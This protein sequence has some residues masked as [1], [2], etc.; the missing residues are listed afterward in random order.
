M[1]KEIRLYGSLGKKFGRVH[2]YAVKSVHE[3]I[4]AL[5]ANFPN[6]EQEFVK[7]N[8]KYR[9]WTGTTR[10]QSAE[11][12]ILPVGYTEVIRISPVV[13]GAG[14]DDMGIFGIILGVALIA[15]SGGIGAALGGSL[16]TAAQVTAFAVNLGVAL[17]LGGVAQMLAPTPNTPEVQERPE[18]KPSQVFSGP[19]N[20]TAQGHPV[21]IGYGRLIVGSAVISAGLSTIELI[22]TNTTSTVSGK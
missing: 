9:I 5:Q 16:M 20:T 1:L 17:I 10:L 19:V 15:F 22:G 4:R 21:P 11:E 6:F 7:D 2:K 14:G 8:A 3:A 18:N 13:S 12:S